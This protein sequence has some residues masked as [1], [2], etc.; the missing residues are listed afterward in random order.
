MMK[1][2]SSVITAPMATVTPVTTLSRNEAEAPLLSPATS[3]SRA[4]RYSDMA[5]SPGLFTSTTSRDGLRVAPLPSSAFSIR[6]NSSGTR[7]VLR[8]LE[9][10]ATCPLN[11]FIRVP[12]SLVSVSSSG[13]PLI[14]PSDICGSPADEANPKL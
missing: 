12:S 13:M 8:R 10:P 1:N 5:T 7:M 6:M 4:S 14:S 11:R 3:R 2:D 9:Y